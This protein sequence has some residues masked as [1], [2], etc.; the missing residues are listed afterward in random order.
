[1]T[2]ISW[3]CGNPACGKTDSDADTDRC[4]T[5]GSDAN[6]KVDMPRAVLRA[7]LARLDEGK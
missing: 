3:R 1:M 2:A 7:L 4:R 5:C 6:V